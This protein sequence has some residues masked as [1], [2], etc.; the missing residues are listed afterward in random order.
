LVVRRITTDA[1]K[2][3]DF[4]LNIKLK[5]KLAKKLNGDIV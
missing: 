3:E 4:A 1:I 2:P 5:G